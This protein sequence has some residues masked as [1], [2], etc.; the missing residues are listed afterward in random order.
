MQTAERVSIAAIC[1][2]ST[3]SLLIRIRRGRTAYIAKFIA[4]GRR[5]QLSVGVVCTLIEVKFWPVSSISLS[6]RTAAKNRKRPD[7][8]RAT[9]GRASG[10]PFYGFLKSSNNMPK[11]SILRTPIRAGRTRAN[12]YLGTHLPA[13]ARVRPRHNR[14]TLGD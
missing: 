14:P 8:V 1:A 11:L 10:R 7:A 9:A 2:A 12:E 5:E 3:P 13:N 6:R 4:Q